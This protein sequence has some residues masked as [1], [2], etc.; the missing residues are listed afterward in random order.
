MENISGFYLL[1]IPNNQYNL[2]CD[3]YNKINKTYC[4]RLRY[5]CA[6]HYKDEYDLKVHT[7]K[8]SN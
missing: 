7:F 5:A 6:E 1:Q 8:R 4:K 2:Y 3:Q